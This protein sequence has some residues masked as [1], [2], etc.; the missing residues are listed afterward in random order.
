MNENKSGLCTAAMVLGI[1]CVATFL[2]PCVGFLPGLLALIFSIVCLAKKK[3]PVGKARAGLITSIIGIVLGFI[4][5]IIWLVIISLSGVA[6]GFFI[7]FVSGIFLTTLQNGN[8]NTTD[9]I[10]IIDNLSNYDYNNMDEEDFLNIFDGTDYE[11]MFSFDEDGNLIY[12]PD[13]LSDY[14]DDNNDINWNNFDG[15]DY[16]WD[17]YNYNDDDYNYDYD[18]DY[19]YDSN[20]YDY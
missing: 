4:F 14:F 3:K 17:Q 15:D 2:I 19:D 10:N 1:I 12:D 7:T 6:I 20:D 16:D 8:A 5:T 9:I 18:Y 11:D 13:D